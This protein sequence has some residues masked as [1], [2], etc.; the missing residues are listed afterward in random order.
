MQVCLKAG[1]L[2][3]RA[4]L[5]VANLGPENGRKVGNCTLPIVLHLPIGPKEVSR[6]LARLSPINALA[7]DRTSRLYIE[8]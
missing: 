2:I 1:R 4:G 7:A 8:L 5:A 3:L 6:F